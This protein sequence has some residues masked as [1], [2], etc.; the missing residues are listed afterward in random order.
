MTHYYGRVFISE[1][2][3]KSLRVETFTETVKRV[4]R[5]ATSSYNE[6]LL[7]PACVQLAKELG[8]G[9]LQSFA[10]RHLELQREKNGEGT[11]LPTNGKREQS[12]RH[13]TPHDHVSLA[14]RER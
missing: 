3:G 14:V 10:V 5:W 9:A 1:Q 8:E 7:T 13:A 6:A 4:R 2:K 11:A 12:L